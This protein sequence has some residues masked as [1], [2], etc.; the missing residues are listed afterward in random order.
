MR[1]DERVQL[2]DDDPV[3]GG[4]MGSERRRRRRRGVV[5]DDGW[6]LVWRWNV[7]WSNRRLSWGETNYSGRA[8][9][10]A[11]PAPSDSLNQAM[12]RCDAVLNSCYSYSI[13]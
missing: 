10:L 3:Y 12:C 1:D 2:V 8:E 9:C 13:W 5:V 4:M 6:Y 11:F 7:W